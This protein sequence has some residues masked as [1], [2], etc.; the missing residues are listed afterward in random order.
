[1]TKYDVNL[2]IGDDLQSGMERK[3]LLALCNLSLH[4]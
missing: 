3:A 2:A 1:M 4:V